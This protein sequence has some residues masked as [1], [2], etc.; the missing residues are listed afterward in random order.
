MRKIYHSYQAA[1]KNKFVKLFSICG[2]IFCFLLS[3]TNV[4]DML[5]YAAEGN[6][7]TFDIGEQVQASL[8]NGVLTISGKGAIRDYQEDTSP[9]LAYKEE[10]QQLVIEDGITHIGDYLFY[11]VGSL[12][13]EVT[14]PESITSFGAYAFSGVDKE[15]APKFTTIQNAFQTGEVVEQQN[16]DQEVEKSITQQIFTKPGTLFY[17]GQQGDVICFS[18]NTSFYKEAEYAGYQKADTMIS[19]ILD[20]KKE[21]HVPVVDGR[22]ILPQQQEDIT[23]T[24]QNTPFYTYEFAGW[25]DTEDTTSKILK[26]ED[27]YQ[28]NGKEQIHLYSAWERIDQFQLEVQTQKKD[29]TAMYQ[30]LD[31]NTKQPLANVQGYTYSYQWQMQDKHAD[32]DSWIS[33]KGANGQVYER[34]M[35]T[36]D[37][38]KEFR[39]IITI[40]NLY[41]STNQDSLSLYSQ[42]VLGEVNKTSIYVNSEIGKDTY[43]GTKESPVQTIE[44]AATLLSRDGTID[45]NEIVLLSDYTWAAKTND[46]PLLGKDAPATTI[47]GDRK[48]IK[49]ISPKLE[50]GSDNP[51]N[52]S[53]DICFQNLTM[54]GNSHIYGNGKNITVKDNV[55]MEK[56]TPANASSEIQSSV[57]LY[58]GGRDNI[59]NGVGKIELHSGNYSRIVGYVRSNTKVNASNTEANITI[60]GT[61][62]VSTIIA[63][64]ASG[65]VINGNVI[66]NIKNGHAGTVV[67]GNQGFNNGNANFAGKT[68]INV[69]GGKVDTIYGAGTGR[70]I[71]VP[72]YLGDI[73]INIT[74]GDIK[75]IYGAGSAGYVISN[76][77]TTSTVNIHAN[78]GTINNIYAAG[79]GGDNAVTATY[80]Q[81]NQS[82]EEKI[83]DDVVNHMGSLTGNVNITIEGN[84]TI[85]QSIYAGGKGYTTVDSNKELDT[86][87][88]AWIKGNVT[89]NVKGGTIK[90]NVYGGGKGFIEEKYNQCA[91]VETDSKIQIIMDDGTVNGNIYGGG[92]NAEI[93]DSTSVVIHGGMVQGNVYGGGEEGLVKNKTNVTITGGIISGSLYGGAKGITNKTYVNQ[94]STVNMSG[95]W[96]RGNVYGGSELS[97]DGIT[98][99]TDVKEETDRIFVNLVGG[100][101]DG[102]AFGGGYQGTTNGSTHLHIGF[103]AMAKCTYYTKNRDEIPKLEKTSLSIGQS[104]YA[105]GDYGGGQ[106]NYDTI[107]VTGH[108]HVYVDGTGYFEDVSNPTITMKIGGGVF[109]S[110][111]SCDA[112]S[113]RMVTLDNFGLAMKNADGKIIDATATLTSVQRADQVRLLNAH[114][115]LTG[116]SDIANANQTVLYS[117]NR[118]GDDDTV[119]EDDILNKLG[120]GLVLDS[121][122]TLVLDS[123]SIEMSSYRSV[124]EKHTTIDTLEQLKT[125]PNTIILKT[126]TVFRVSYSKMVGNAD[127]V[128][129]YGPVLGYS[130]IEADDSVKAYAYARQKKESPNS[131]NDGGFYV[132]SATA[133]EELSSTDVDG[134]PAYRYWSVGGSNGSISSR[135]VVLTAKKQD[136][137]SI[138]GKYSVTEGMVELPPTQAN[139]AYH[140][141]NMEMPTGLNLASAAVDGN[142]TWQYVT[143][144]A[145]NDAIKEELKGKISTETST[146]GLFVAQGENITIDGGGKVLT[147]EKATDGTAFIKEDTDGKIPT[148]KFYLTYDNNI[149]ISKDLG[150][151]K[152]TVDHKKGDVVLET[153]HLEIEIITKT[154]TLSEQTI[155]LYATKNGNYTTQMIVPEGAQRTLSLTSVDAKEGLVSSGSTLT[156]NQY[157]ITMK[158]VKTQG[159]QSSGLH[160]EAIDLKGFTKEVSLGTTDSRYEAPIEFTLY[161]IPNFTAKDVNDIVTITLGEGS[162]SVNITLRIH[163]QDSIVSAIKH[164]PGKQFNTFENQ[165]N[166]LISSKSA[167]TS[168]FTTSK[169]AS[170][171]VIWLEIQD[172]NNNTVRY[173]AGMKLI[174]TNDYKQYYVYTTKGNEA[175]N[176]IQLTDFK[177]MWEN[178]TSLSGNI[179]KDTTF[180][181]TLDLGDVDGA[182]LSPGEYSLRMRTGDTADSMGSDFTIDASSP[183]I[184]FKSTSVENNKYNLHVTITPSNDTVFM[185]GA[186]VVLSPKDGTKFPT[187]ATFTYQDKVY[188]IVNGKVAIPLQSLS[189]QTIV[190]DVSSVPNVDDVEQYIE[191]KVF[192]TGMNATGCSSVY[193]AEGIYQLN[194]RTEYA[195]KVEPDIDAKNR[196]I[197]AGTNMKFKVGYL[198]KNLVGDERIQVRVQQKTND[199]YV[200]REGFAVNGNSDI[201][202]TD[203][204]STQDIGI[205]VPNDAAKGTYRLVFTL[206]N[207]TEYYH[208]IIK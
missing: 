144:T 7:T 20:D 133:D 141:I 75:D 98:S 135:K 81:N 17:Q 16:D 57:Y 93:E 58:G 35:E 68:Q 117:L 126:G 11:N 204:T 5:T 132:I 95:G 101:I 193:T 197:S 84:T 127:A 107:T 43:T 170:V 9:F 183:K 89:I 10:I 2:L 25:R 51:L 60:D 178:S 187:G 128:E 67:G 164:A 115:H 32:K 149:T 44:K 182:S 145:E 159:W 71:S 202:N 171:N 200:D 112:G 125:S 27:V 6:V 146:F 33:I 154:T 96:V 46:A 185:Q 190:M 48:E 88:N 64:N 184:E 148:V 188:P 66:I 111:A 61:A 18:T 147:S 186:A 129:T 136:T 122:S 192:A 100:T 124:D 22:I 3:S 180:Y 118:I 52:L 103:G 65:E 30:V 173:P 113:T 1:N 62:D 40:D 110:G 119:K 198:I 34:T 203:T 168:S 175:E 47:R 92:E 181:I 56:Y 87:K 23:C 104:A 14:F 72:T 79:I 45:T 97:N 151:I 38:E 205:Q 99:N 150:T 201:G 26:V 155:D 176:H 120:K 153:I 39:C 174:L 114:V 140:I 50:N 77:T 106:N 55:R 206:G 179:P 31:S 8:Q 138:D 165:D 54:K 177:K 194:K 86:T 172:K 36:R 82:D 83:T 42:P 59:N 4:C 49:F 29:T 116:A 123:A 137:P 90:G 13:G 161:N 94:G 53:N 158:P 109:G 169:A 134:S 37:A 152:V 21:M 85:N 105:G 142:Y 74:G 207:Q 139:T 208:F 73:D 166:I 195:L 131:A 15:S 12:S 143:G 162:S 63:G 19:L 108:S 160:G 76:N 91:R 196:V 130:Y 24:Y 163:W 199:E 156:G 121:G 189:D 70:N 191:V 167:F 69:S 28:V 80:Q 41:R 78:G 157:A 102:K